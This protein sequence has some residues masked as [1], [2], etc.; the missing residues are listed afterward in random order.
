M[1]YQSPVIFNEQ[2]HSYFNPVSGKWLQ[3]ITGI[4][5]KHVFPEMYSNIPQSIL[6]NAAQKG[7]NIHEECEDV[8]MFS[9]QG[10]TDEGKAYASLLKA[11]NIQPTATEYTISDEDYF[12]SK[13]DMVD[14]DN[15]LFDIK[16]TSVLNKDYVSWQLS[17]YAYLFERQNKGMRAGDLFAIHLRGKKARLI[18]VARVPEGE[19]KRLLNCEVLGLPFAVSQTLPS[20]ADNEKALCQLA[21]YERAIID[22]KTKMDD[23]EDKKKNIL[24]GIAASM[25]KEGLYKIETPA[26]MLTRVAESQ[27][28]TLDSKSLKTDMPEVYNRYARQSVRKGYLK[29]TVKQ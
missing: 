14:T 23:Y 8:A 1:L 20:V 9:L 10:K 18:K 25:E 15:N 22:L 28:V 12:A 17:I 7:K 21:D 16:T 19:V 26:I 5:H 6:D 3:G 11:Y 27:A 4:L 2:Q 29:I 24:E 13:I